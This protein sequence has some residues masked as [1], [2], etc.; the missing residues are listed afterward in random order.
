MTKNNSSVCTH[1]GPVEQKILPALR[2]QTTDWVTQAHAH[3]RIVSNEQASSLTARTRSVAI[4]V[5]ANR[6]G[7]STYALDLC[8]H[9]NKRT[10]PVQ[11][12]TLRWLFIF[13]A[14][15]E[16]S[17]G[18]WFSYMK[19]SVSKTSWFVWR[20]SRRPHPTGSCTRRGTRD[21]SE[22]DIHT[23]TPYFHWTAQNK[24]EEENK[25]TPTE[26][27]S[28]NSPISNAIIHQYTC[29]PTK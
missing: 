29:R 11:Q 6:I 22:Y 14:G 2:K 28:R 20:A 24:R 19:A 16:P 4:S 21:T 7:C 15:N 1:V 25:S 27:N 12:Y 18:I 3:V 10:L 9:K 5:W 13:T 17:H 8:T 26:E 23:H